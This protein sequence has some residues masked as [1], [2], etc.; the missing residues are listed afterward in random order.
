MDELLQEINKNTS[1]EVIG[2]TGSVGKT[3]FARMLNDAL[4]INDITQVIISKRL[5]PLIIYDFY[6]NKLQKETKYIIAEIGL[7]L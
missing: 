6:F 7:F 2:I 3:T 4:S 1:F 5:T